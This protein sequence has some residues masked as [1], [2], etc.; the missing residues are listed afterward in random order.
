MIFKTKNSSVIAHLID[1]D[2]YQLI[3]VLGNPSN[4]EKNKKYFVDPSSK[5]IVKPNQCESIYGALDHIVEI[6]DLTEL[7]KL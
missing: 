1:K 5:H 3:D 6:E 4:L 7:N 2:N